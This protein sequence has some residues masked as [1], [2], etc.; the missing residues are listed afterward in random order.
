MPF[1]FFIDSS[2][3]FYAPV[4]WQI[5][6]REKIPGSPTQQKNT[7][8]GPKQFN[9][10]KLTL[11]CHLNKP[12]PPTIDR[13][14][15]F[16]LLTFRLFGITRLLFHC[17]ELQLRFVFLL[18]FHSRSSLVLAALP[19]SSSC[20]ILPLVAILPPLWSPSSWYS[21]MLPT[22]NFL[23]LSLLMCVWCLYLCT[24]LA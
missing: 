6:V 13:G 10:M 24:W 3:R 23:L 4:T 15:P 19:A 17:Q 1:P 14:F 16:L 9:V 22:N 12:S 5:L 2:C 8:R 21:I 18:R 7:T 11:D 20:R